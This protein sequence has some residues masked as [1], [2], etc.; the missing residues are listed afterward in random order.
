MI[1]Y[2]VKPLKRYAEISY[3]VKCVAVESE[4]VFGD[5]YVTQQTRDLAYRPDDIPSIYGRQRRNL[6]HQTLDGP[7]FMEM[8]SKRPTR[9]SSRWKRR[10]K[11]AGDVPCTIALNYDDVGDRDVA[12]RRPKVNR[13]GE[14]KLR[15]VSTCPASRV[16]T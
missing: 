1:G 8:N 12:V 15:R 6:I 13:R 11:S 14:V 9:Q 10:S 7:D 16:L 3:R 4:R 2:N 5:V